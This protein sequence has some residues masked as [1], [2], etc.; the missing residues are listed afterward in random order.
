[1]KRKILSAILI[2]MFSLSICSTAVFSDSD[3]TVYLDGAQ[4]SFDVSPIIA[5][6]R[7]LVPMRGVFEAL[8]AAVSWDDDTKTATALNSESNRGISITVG[9]NIM[10]DSDGNKIILDVP[11]RIENGRTLLPLR[12]VSEAFYCTVEWDDLNRQVIIAS[13]DPTYGTDIL[14]EQKTVEVANTEELLNSIGSDKKIVLTGTY[15]NL[16]DDIRVSNPYV[17]KYEDWSGYK[18]KDVANMTIIGNNSEIVIDDILSD[19]LLFDNCSYIELNGLRVGHTKSLP[20]Y[21][22]EGSVTSFYS[23]QNINI[24]NCELYG[25]GAIGINAYDTKKIKVSGGR[26]YDCSYTGIWL[27]DGST[28]EVSKT[29]FC[30]SNHMSGFIRTDNSK[31]SLTEC[32][33]HDIICEDI[34]ID[35]FDSKTPSEITIKNCTFENISYSDFIT[36]NYVNITMDGCIFK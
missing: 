14:K 17:E 27:S 25:C 5:D 13:E 11:A 4:L 22:C 8:G 3:I 35:T 33:I 36:S 29:E 7:V 23:C 30:D 26:I 10:L 20:E 19:V 16:S 2:L 21:T 31:I 34:F 24:E 15:Y 9:S 18:I 32:S 12:A 1:M 28:A 6:S